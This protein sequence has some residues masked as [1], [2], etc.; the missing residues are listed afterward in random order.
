M[1]PQWRGPCLYRARDV[2]PEGTGE[3][4]GDSG[5]SPDRSLHSL[6]VPWLMLGGGVGREDS[7]YDKGMRR[8]PPLPRWLILRS[9]V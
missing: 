5:T 9:G 4:R 1:A 3:S 8:P 6:A 2:V 7:A